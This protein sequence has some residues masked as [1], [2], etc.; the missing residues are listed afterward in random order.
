MSVAALREMIVERGL[1]SES[2]AK[3]MKKPIIIEALSK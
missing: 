3:K 2:D 1:S